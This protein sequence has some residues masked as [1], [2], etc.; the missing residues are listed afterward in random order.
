MA[1][2]AA[3]VAGP[4]PEIA[5][6]KQATMTQTIA[7]PCLVW[8]TRERKKSIRRVEMPLTSMMLPPRMKKGMASR[9]Y[10]F[11]AV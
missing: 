7:R 2:S 8:P 11:E 5:A 4:E 3:T 10:L 6:K 9:T 1:P